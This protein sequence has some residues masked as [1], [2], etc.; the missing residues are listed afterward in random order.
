[1][2]R[3]KIKKIF[4]SLTKNEN[5]ANKKKKQ[6]QISF[7][8]CLIVNDNASHKITRVVVVS[9]FWPKQNRNENC[10]LTFLSVLH[11]SLS[12]P[13]YQPFLKVC[14]VHFHM[15]EMLQ[16]GDKSFQ[17]KF[18]DVNKPF[19]FWCAQ[20]FYWLLRINKWFFRSES[21]FNNSRQNYSE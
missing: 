7:T 10:V 9:G 15:K 8:A 18:P 17:M 13:V 21:V 20:R 19:F 16:W 5:N 4:H 6:K 1:M 11:S 3:R 14:F 2:I 12:L